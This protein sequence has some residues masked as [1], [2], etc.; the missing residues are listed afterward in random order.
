MDGVAEL[1]WNK[2]QKNEIATFL[3]LGVLRLQPSIR[4]FP[5]SPC[6][7]QM[8]WREAAV[9]PGR[10]GEYSL[11]RCNNNVHVHVSLFERSMSE[12]WIGFM[13]NLVYPKWFVS[14]RCVEMRVGVCVCVSVRTRMCACRPQTRVW[15]V[16][17][18]GSPLDTVGLH[19]CLNS[20]LQARETGDVK[21]FEAVC[22]WCHCLGK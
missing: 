17:T 4:N 7:D 16:N 18:W 5:P 2:G 14:L 8:E 22:R 13:L 1:F 10:A 12:E 15:S 9:S 21:G 20:Q 6:K 11:R 3:K 19:W